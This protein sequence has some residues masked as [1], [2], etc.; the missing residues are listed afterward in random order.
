LI[1]CVHGLNNKKRKHTDIRQNVIS[2]PTRAPRK[3]PKAKAVKVA[4]VKYV[5]ISNSNNEIIIENY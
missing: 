3:A 4:N 1:F 5:S 2:L